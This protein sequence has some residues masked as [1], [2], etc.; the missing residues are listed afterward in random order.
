METGEAAALEPLDDDRG[1]FAEILGQLSGSWKLQEVAER[2]A[3]EIGGWCGSI[4]VASY[5]P[6]D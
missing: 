6:N 5:Q 2:A 4:E 3:A 1:N